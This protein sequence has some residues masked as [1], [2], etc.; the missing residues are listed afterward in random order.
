MPFTHSWQVIANLDGV[1]DVVIT[2]PADWQGLVYN[3]ATWKWENET[4]LGSWDMLRSIYDTDLD[5]VVDT[6][7]DVSKAP[8]ITRTSVSAI[9][10]LRLNIDAATGD[11]A[12]TT[13][14]VIEDGKYDIQFD[15]IAAWCS[16]EFDTAVTRVW[17]KTLKLSTT[18]ITWT[19]RA[20]KWYVYAFFIKPST[21]YKLSCWVKT[22]NAAVNSAFIA[23]QEYNSALGVIAWT[24]TNW[25]SSTLSWTNDWTLLT[26]TV[27][28]NATAAIFNIFFYNAV[29][30]NIS[31]VWYDI[32][33]MTL[34]EVVEPVANSLTSSSPSLVSFTAVGS[35][36][37]IDQSFLTTPDQWRWLWNF[38]GLQY[39]NSQSFTATKSK[40]TWVYLYKRANVWTPTWNVKIDIRTDN[41]WDPS[42]TILATYTI[43]LATY[44]A[45]TTN[46]EFLVNLPCNLTAWTKYHIVGSNTATEASWNFFNLWA[47]AAWGYTWGDQRFSTNWGTTWSINGTADLYFKTLYYKPTTNFKASQ[48]NQSVSISADE[49]GFLNWSVYNLSTGTATF[50]ETFATFYLL[51]YTISG[52]DLIA[53]VNLP[54]VGLSASFTCDRTLNYSSDWVTYGST[55]PTW[56]SKVWVKILAYSG[57]ASFSYSIQFSTTSLSTLRNYPT[58]KDVITTYQKSLAAATTSATYRAT[59]WGFPAIEYSA[60]EYQYLDIDPTAIGSTI[61]FSSNGSAYTTVV[62]GGSLVITS[63]TTPLL[64]VKTNITA[65]RLLISSN[66]YTVSSDKDASNKMTIGYQ[67]LSQ[68]LT[69]D[70]REL[71]KD[72]EALMI[73]NSQVITAITGEIR[74]EADVYTIT[75]ITTGNINLIAVP[76]AWKKFTI[77]VKTSGTSSYTLTFNTGFKSTWTLA[78]GTVDAKYFVINFISDGIQALELSRTT[79]M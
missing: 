61:A 17:V 6:S 71:Q 3:S 57:F 42:S 40:L 56:F 27:T 19:C 55:F 7:D 51:Q 46:S 43:P 67:V 38:S 13:S 59:K 58:N 32:H 44:N 4:I 50:T 47:L 18:D 30:W 12:R 10:G 11:I 8:L 76:E 62:D 23:G 41:A 54:W 16:G 33:T 15:R 36:D 74:T 26:K 25:T 5:G 14:G 48:N 72:V 63:T 65:N 49:D 66:D 78:T 28:T 22:N 64:W 9:W 68:G 20:I 53:E 73:E 29:A 31:D 34:E 2:A 60:T 79:A 35:T 39:I 75:P 70:M 69:Y 21:K 37:N 45:L 77:I 1:P 24:F 52:S